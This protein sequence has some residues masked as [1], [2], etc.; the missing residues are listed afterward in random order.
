[1]QHNVTDDKWVM[2]INDIGNEEEQLLSVCYVRNLCSV[3][4]DNNSEY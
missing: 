1:M 3:M 2:N 4:G